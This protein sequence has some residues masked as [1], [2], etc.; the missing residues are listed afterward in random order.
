LCR[1]TL[2][3]LAQTRMALPHALLQSGNHLA[4]HL[5]YARMPSSNVETNEL[6]ALS[7][8]TTRS[9]P[10]D[11][12]DV[13]DVAK[14]TGVVIKRRSTDR[15]Q[16]EQIGDVRTEQTPPIDQQA[17]ATFAQIVK[18]DARAVG[19][20]IADGARTLEHAV[21]RELHKVEDEVEEEYVELKNKVQ[22]GDAFY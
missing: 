4:S 2:A 15:S 9:K 3:D 12:A 17:S 13:A 1:L 22:Q 16:E 18:H 14:E 19:K 10:A 5:D 6:P 21:A 20:D 7:G 8:T 11:V